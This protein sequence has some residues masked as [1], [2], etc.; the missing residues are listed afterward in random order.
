MESL[1]HFCRLRRDFWPVAAVLRRAVTVA[2]SPPCGTCCTSP[3]NGAVDSGRRVERTPTEA[4]PGR[5]PSVRR[6]HFLRGFFSMAGR[7]SFA[8]LFRGRRESATADEV[9]FRASLCQSIAFICSASRH[10]LTVRAE[11]ILFRLCQSP[12]LSPHAG[13]PPPSRYPDPDLVSPASGGCARRSKEASRRVIESRG[14]AQPVAYSSTMAPTPRRRGDV[15]RSRPDG[16]LLGK[17]QRA[18]RR[19]SRSLRDACMPN[20][21]RT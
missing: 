13:T 2:V 20:D 4:R 19:R 16:D 1:R 18:G 15:L 21:S 8:R 14:Y 11:V 6:G 12:L 10:V 3:L 17:A 7:P 5:L 9:G